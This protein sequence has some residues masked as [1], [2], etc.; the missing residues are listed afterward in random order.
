MYIDKTTAPLPQ[1]QDGPL[2]VIKSVLSDGLILQ[3]KEL[4]RIP[5][6]S[7]RITFTLGSTYLGQGRDVLLAYRLDGVDEKWIVSGDDREAEYHSLPAGRYTFEVRAYSRT[8]PDSWKTTR[9]SLVIPVVWY[10]GPWFYILSIAFLAVS[11]VLFYMLRLRRIRERFRLILE[12]RTR[13]ARE[14]H[15]TLTQGCNGVAMLLKAEA[16]R[17]GRPGSSSLDLAREQLQATVAD[18]RDAIWNLRQTEAAPGFI[19]SSLKN[20]A[21]QAT[22]SFGIPVSL[23]DADDHYGLRGMRERAEMIGANLKIASDKGVGTHVVI[24]LRAEP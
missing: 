8:H 5:S 23:V 9:L 6:G 16:S 4:T 21:A 20:L 22:E 2:P 17:G 7:K 18:A 13:L 10:R 15:D 19:V 3:K 14:M 12:E 24:S 11:S 1:S